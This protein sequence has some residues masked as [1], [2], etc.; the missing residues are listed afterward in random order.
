MT[1]VILTITLQN[2]QKIQTEVSSFQ[3]G[4][5]LLIDLD[6]NEEV[7]DYHFDMKGSD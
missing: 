6:D 1:K 3:E 2:E 4:Y 7:I 5:D